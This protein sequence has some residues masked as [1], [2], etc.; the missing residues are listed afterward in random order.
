MKIGRL[1]RKGSFLTPVLTGGTVGAGFGLL[2]A[3]QSGHETRKDIEKIAKR[4]THAVGVGKDLYG[5][6]KVFVN[7]AI[8]AG[9]TAFVEAKPLAPIVN[10]KSPLL[11]P[12]IVAGSIGI[13]GAGIALLV[14]PKK[15]KDIRHDLKHFASTSRDT[16]ASA[17]DK[18]KVVYMAGKDAI[19]GAA[20]A[21]RKAFSH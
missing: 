21:S 13:I 12:V 6:G 14:A 3:P 15:G 2:F 7:K 16:V 1:Y 19:Y 8:E 17:I 20:K 5:E 9:K 11:V 10:G 4:V 18:G